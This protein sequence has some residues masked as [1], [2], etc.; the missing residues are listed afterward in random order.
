MGILRD[1]I[2]D[3]ESHIPVAVI[4]AG[5]CGLAAALAA[6]DAGR[7]V[8]VFE[9][10]ERPWGSTSMSLGAA[11]AAGSTAQRDAGVKDS[12]ELFLADV[13][14]KTDGRA[15]AGLAKVVAERSG[16]TMDWL[17]GHQVPM[18]LDFKWTGL[19]HSR[20]R[21]HI[22]PGRNG[23]E[24]LALLLNACARAGA[25]VMTSARVVDLY[26]DPDDRVRGLRIERP[27]GEIE[28]IGCDAVVIATCGFGGDHA[29]VAEHIP[30]MA[31]ARYFGHEGNQGDGIRFGAALGGA[32]ADMS[33]YQ[34]LGT[35]ADPQ[36]VVVPHPLLIEGGFLVNAE[37]RR[38][39]HELANISG[40]CVPV[41][42]QPGGVAWVVFDAQRHEACL[43]H[44][45]EQRQLVEVGALRRGTTWSELEQACRLPAGSLT[46]EDAHIA[47][48]RRA[49][50]A[51]RL[52]RDFSGLAPLEPP[53]YAVRVTGA[54]FHTQGGLRVDSEA[55]VLRADGRALPNVFAGGGAARSISGPAVTGY[56]PGAGLCMALTLG[57]IAGTA[58][59]AIASPT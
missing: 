11:C 7:D 38:F 33:A 2:P 24:L 1:R 52:G 41:L 22:P 6:R 34:G 31:N 3:F 58:A 5:A 37:G 29:M 23:E 15:D 25:E 53:Y 55:R 18:Q 36:Q 59:A 50:R 57:R 44:S 4:G 9:R 49:G 47:A 35:L 10:D 27:G 12:A 17:T 32:L 13:M 48:A 45:V 54:L 19:G 8:I 51:D 43:A 16:P 42:A 56:L 20:P 39:T 28:E 21:L 26:A 14:A 46:A 30:E 40:M